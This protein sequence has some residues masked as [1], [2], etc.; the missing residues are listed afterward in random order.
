MRKLTIVVCILA[1][2]A[3]A[4]SGCGSRA[5]SSV[6]EPTGVARETTETSVFY[7]TGRSLFEERTVVDAKNPYLAALDVLLAAQPKT[8]KNL[9]IVQP[10]AK[11]NSV[12]VKDGIATVDWAPAVL[13]FN[14]EPKEKMLALASVLRTLGEFPEVKR[15]RFTV[16]GK[17]GGTV[18]GKDIESFWG[19]VSLKGQPWD[20]LRAAPASKE[21]S[22]TQ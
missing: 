20:V 13:S 14:A 15:V 6:P 22:T 5:G 10:Q 9:A 21:T 7:S 19:S 12:A 18:G 16:D 8:D 17:T 4:L 1:L 11:V 3:V 2:A